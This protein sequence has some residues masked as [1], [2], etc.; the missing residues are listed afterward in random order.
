MKIVFSYILLIFFLNSEAQDI[1]KQKSVTDTSY[2]KKITINNKSVAKIEIE[3]DYPGGANAWAR[4]LQ[5][6]LQYP[7]KAIRKKIEGTVVVQ[8]IVDK[9]G[10]VSDIQAISGPENGGLKEEAIRVIKIS[11]N[12]RPAVQDGRKVKSYKK[13]PITFR[14]Q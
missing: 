8:F 3:S 7:N 11:G 4:F 10:S 12:W 5:A 9:D 14:L 13:Q 1:S 6:N 2:A